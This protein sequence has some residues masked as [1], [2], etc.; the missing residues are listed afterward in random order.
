MVPTGLY[1]PRIPKLATALTAVFTLNCACNGPTVADSPITE[2]QQLEDKVRAQSA[3]LARKNEELASQAETIRE[4]RGFSGDRS[5]DQF[6]H[7][8]RIE[9]ERLSGGYDDDRDEVDEGVVAYLRLYDSDG[10][11]IKAS[12]SAILEA[13]DLAA[14]EGQQL[15]AKIAVDVAAMRSLWYGKFMTSHYTLKAPWLPDRAPR[16]GS[17]TIVARF[18]DLLSGEVFEAQRVANV[19]VKGPAL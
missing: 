14:P 19:K 7:V 13:Y 10:D 6:V 1:G 17:I 4:L 16:H 5:I 2:M 8:S 11:I 9:I 15:V 12:G 3:E 18:A